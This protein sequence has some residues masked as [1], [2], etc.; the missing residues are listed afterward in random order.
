M[1]NISNRSEA[2]QVLSGLTLGFAA[3]P[4]VRW[5]YPEPDV[6]LAHFPRVADLFGGRAFENGAAYR[7]DDF[8]ATALWLPPRVHPDEEG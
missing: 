4:V 3:D 8:T 1:F 2:D 6:Y 7:N 5:V